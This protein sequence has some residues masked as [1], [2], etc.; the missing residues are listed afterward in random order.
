M[1]K[2]LLYDFVW[3]GIAIVC[4]AFISI[5]FALYFDNSPFLKTLISFIGILSEVLGGV[6]SNSLSI[7]L[8][9]VCLLVIFFLMSFEKSVE[10]D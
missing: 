4:G 10:P 1:N 5:S 2:E 9:F 6:L 8:I 7:I 3:I